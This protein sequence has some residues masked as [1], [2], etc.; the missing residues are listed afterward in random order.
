MIVSSNFISNSYACIHIRFYVFA[1]HFAIVA[2]HCPT[3]E[4][5]FVL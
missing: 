3:E 4:E 5:S 1:I 2:I